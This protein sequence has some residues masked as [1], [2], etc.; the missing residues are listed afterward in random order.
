MADLPAA[1]AATAS[2]CFRGVWRDYQAQLLADADALLDDKR[3]HIVAAPGS[4]KTTLGIEVIRRIGRPAV[5]LAPTVTIRDQ[6][7]DR[8]VSGFTEAPHAPGWISSSLDD[9][10]ELTVPPADRAG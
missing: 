1:P 4:G 8:L 6:W 10:R 7:I 3:F 9:P 5:V 2:L